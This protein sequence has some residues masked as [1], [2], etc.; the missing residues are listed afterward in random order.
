MWILPR[1]LHTSVSALGTEALISDSSEQSQA[2]AQWLLVRSK[3]SPVRTWCLRWSRDTWTQHLSGRILRPSHT[4]SFVTAWTSSLGVTHASHSQLLESDLERTTPATSGHSSQMELLPCDQGYVSL[5]TSK[6]ISAWGCPTSS[7]TWQQWVIERRGAY[8]QRLKSERL[9]QGSGCSS[10]PT[11]NA[12]DWKDSPGMATEAVNP[13]GSPRD[14]TDQLA[15]A[16]YAAGPAVQVINKTYGNRP[17]LWRTPNSQ[18][19]EA[20]PD[21][22]KLFHR[23]PQDPQVGL[24]DQVKSWATPRSGKTTDENPETWAKR[25]EKGD[26]STM[27]LTAQVKAWPTPASSTGNGGAHGLDGGS[28]ARSMISPEDAAAMKGGKLNPRWVETLMGLLVGWTMPSC[29]SPVT[30]GQT[31]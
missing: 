5:R 26:V 3:P 7:K 10:W 4:Q 18:L 12:R 29:A 1:Q 25:N 8:S 6:D 13:D 20:K 30:I 15:R 16:V 23:T 27:P 14:R 11:A 22:I 24:A 9:T 19:I 17:E 31:S 2:C 28:G 21:G